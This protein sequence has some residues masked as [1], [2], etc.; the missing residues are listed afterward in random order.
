MPAA[1]V[2]A[3]PPID[4]VLSGRP[5]TV[6]FGGSGR[7]T[8]IICG[9][10]GCERQAD[11]LFLGGLPPVF[12]VNLRNQETAQWLEQSV[13]YLVAEAEAQ[14]P[15]A[16]ALLSRMAEA[17]FVETLRARMNEGADDIGWLAGARDPIVGGAL[18][19]IHR[20]PARAWTVV[21]LAAEVGTSRSVL[22]E[23]FARYLD[24]APLEYLTRWRLQLGARQ[25][26]TSSSSVL[27]IAVGVGYQ[28]ESGFN[29]AFKRQFGVP[30]GRF[31]QNIHPDE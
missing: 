14:R 8:S 15:G 23:R 12:S 26:R 18:A 30:P 24:E 19:A 29:R 27:E 28:S 13:R 9:F 21:Q 31:R 25:L 7:P 17:L 10:L 11:R 6:R 1:L 3:K 22:G 16:S 20:E 2:D 4:E 5:R